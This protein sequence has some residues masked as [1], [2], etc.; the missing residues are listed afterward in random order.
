MLSILIPTYN[1]DVLPLI[2]ELESQANKLDFPFE[3]ICIDDYSSK[4]KLEK[5]K[6]NHL[7]NTSLILLKE[8][9]GRSAIR[10]LLAQKANYNNLLFIDAGT[11][12]K[13]DNFI[14]NYTADLN[15]PVV[16][17]GMVAEEIAPKKPYKLRWLYTKE[18]EVL[19]KNGNNRKVLT[20][21]NFLIKK[22][23]IQKHVFDETITKY[24]YEDFVFFNTLKSQEIKLHFINNPVIH[25]S[26][27]S[28]DIFIKKNRR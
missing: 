1:Y 8:N 11:F 14:K 12:P 26:K 7:N 10:N 6:I 5:E 19:F 18:R 9:I 16:L 20:S 13:S 25:D 15:Q 24:G 3:I 23:I 21:T 17:G 4:F 22:E 2:T 28:A 27:E